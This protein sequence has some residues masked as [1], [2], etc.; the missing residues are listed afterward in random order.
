MSNCVQIIHVKRGVLII[1]PRASKDIDELPD[2][3]RSVAFSV[4]WRTICRAGREI[5]R[6]SVSKFTNGHIGLPWMRLRA[7]EKGCK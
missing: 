7:C 2:N 3:A 6:D 1:R 4:F 5:T